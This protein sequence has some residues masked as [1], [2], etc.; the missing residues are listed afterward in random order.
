MLQTIGGHLSN[1]EN[2]PA[3]VLEDPDQGSTRA[4]AKTVTSMAHSVR[5][6]ILLECGTI[7]QN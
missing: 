5:E 6:H 4:V 7:I 1:M 2:M 3:T